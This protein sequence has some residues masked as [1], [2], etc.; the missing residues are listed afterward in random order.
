M[1]K[2]DIVNK[3]ILIHDAI[4]K[5]SYFCKLYGI[6]TLF[7]VGGYC[8]AMYMDELWK[9]NDIDVA[10]AYE[11]QAEQLCGLFA[12]EVLKTMPEFYKRSGA[13]AVNYTSD[14]GTIKIEFQ[15]RSVNEYMNNKEV[16]EW[17]HSQEIED[18]PIMHNIFGRDF[19][20]NALLMGMSDG[21][22]RDPTGLAADDLE[23]GTIRSLLPAEMLVKYNPLAILRAI[24]F[25]LTYD[26]HI[27]E[28]LR[29]AMQ[30]GVGA[31][32]KT[33][34]QERIMKEIVRILKV[35]GPKALEMIQKY[36]L[37]QF[38]MSPEVK[39]YLRLE[40]RDD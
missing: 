22:L 28:S 24:R 29:V 9:V 15:G 12:S 21:I 38:L 7:V 34:S 17:M 4:A 18:V 37:G 40:V 30:S 27:E 33:L 8:R 1:D 5:L 11:D 31:L 13:G 16:R 19:T 2:Q 25:A 10:S 39:D 3:E 35:D 32:T 23:K 20:I 14:E 26:F 36:N 6:N